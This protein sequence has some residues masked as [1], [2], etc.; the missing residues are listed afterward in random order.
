MGAAIKYDA[1]LLAI[2]LLEKKKELSPMFPNNMEAGDHQ[3][4][5]FVTSQG[6]RRSGSAPH[7]RP[8]STFF[9]SSSKDRGKR[10]GSGVHVVMPGRSQGDADEE[11]EGESEER[12]R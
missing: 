9:R 10:S 6:K 4:H 1:C 5:F 12:L 2:M 7:R 11:G 8:E 3:Q